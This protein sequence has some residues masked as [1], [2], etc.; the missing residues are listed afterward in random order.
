MKYS[1]RVPATHRGK[2][3]HLI[4]FYTAPCLWLQAHELGVNSI[5]LDGPDSWIKTLVDLGIVKKFLPINFEDVAAVFDKALGAIQQLKHVCR[6]CWCC[7]NIRRVSMDV[8]GG[9]S[10]L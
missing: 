4:T 2:V 3:L 7:L 8:A 10:P 1:A 9:L 5:V 6:L